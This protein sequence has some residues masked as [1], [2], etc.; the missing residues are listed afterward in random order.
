MAMEWVEA[1]ERRVART[2]N[3]RYRLLCA[4]D[5]PDHEA[6][7]ANIVASE[8]G[9]PAAKAPGPE[10]ITVTT[11]V[12]L[13]RAMKSCPFRSIEGCGCTGGRCALRGGAAV[14]HLDC[15]P[16]VERYG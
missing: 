11:S 16:C 13:T 10:S 15:F 1:L 12:A 8:S 2:G 7:R 14:S 4:D 3:E 6:W 5:H 9:I